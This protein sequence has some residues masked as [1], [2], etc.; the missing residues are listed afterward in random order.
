MTA[1]SM[2][3]PRQDVQINVHGEALQLPSRAATALALVCNE[4]VQNA[5][6]HAFVELRGRS[7]RYF[8][9]PFT[10]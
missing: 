10:R 4:L 8:A 9:R 3:R 6:E 2:V 7:D 5:L 1:G